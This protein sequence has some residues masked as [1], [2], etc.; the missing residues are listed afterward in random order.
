MY[1]FFIKVIIVQCG[2]NAN[3]TDEEKDELM[4]KCK[5]YERIL[6][7]N[8]VRVKGILRCYIITERLLI[9]IATL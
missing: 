9:Y 1:N 2:I 3:T 5:E 4:T 8:S 6:V 7:A